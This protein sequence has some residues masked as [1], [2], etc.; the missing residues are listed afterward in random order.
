N[1]PPS[2]DVPHE[3]A[4]EHLRLALKRYKEGDGRLRSLLEARAQ[5]V[6][7]AHRR[8][9]RAA[10]MRVREVGVQLVDWDLLGLRILVPQR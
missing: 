8:A 10:R 6:Q 5:E 1:L 9:R 2:G 3:E 4:E 7:G